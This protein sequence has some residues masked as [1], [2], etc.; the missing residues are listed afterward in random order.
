M[1]CDVKVF[2]FVVEPSK[3]HQFLSDS[4]E[5]LKVTPTTV[6]EAYNRD[7]YFK[8][9]EEP[10]QSKVISMYKS[11]VKKDLKKAHYQESSFEATEMIGKLN[12]FIEEAKPPIAEDPLFEKA[13]A[14]TPKTMAAKSPEMNDPHQLPHKKKEELDLMGG[15]QH[16]FDG[17]FRTLNM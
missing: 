9:F 3:I 11:K 7:D 2:V 5:A 15:P 8:L 10:S 6:V 13:V 17:L 4:L 16:I 12:K 14:E 1:L